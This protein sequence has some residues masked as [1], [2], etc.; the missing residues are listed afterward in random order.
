MISADF[1]GLALGQEIASMARSIAAAFA[2]LS[3]LVVI[4]RRGLSGK[5]MTPGSLMF[6]VYWLLVLAVTA[7]HTGLFSAPL[8]STLALI[9]LLATAQSAAEVLR[10]LQLVARAYAIL[11]LPF[12]FLFFF[13]PET[14]APSSNGGFGLLDFR[15][16]GFSAH[17]GLIS[18][19]F[20]LG[21]LIEIGS[22]NPRR[23]FWVLAYS[24]MFLLAQSAGAFAALLVAALVLVILQ[25]RANRWIIC[26]GGIGGTTAALIGLWSAGRLQDFGSLTTGRNAIWSDALGASLEEPL[27]GRGSRYKTL[28]SSEEYPF[29]R[30]ASHTHNDVL[31]ALITS[32]LVGVTLLLC[33][34]SYVAIR[35][36]RTPRKSSSTAGEPVLAA[37]IGVFILVYGLVDTPLAPGFGPMLLVIAFLLTFTANKLWAEPEGRKA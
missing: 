13:S 30:A 32:G 18:A 29:L 14:G 1:I 37:S 9:L 26:L 6:I 36:I 12:L 16:T 17:P 21:I 11:S 28:L 31:E 22:R 4:W 34:A 25:E 10:A 27:L 15:F 20:S 23:W 8:L 5:W 19:V 24:G 7:F 2:V 3:L 35:L 33:S